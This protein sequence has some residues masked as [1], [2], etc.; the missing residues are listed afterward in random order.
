MLSHANA[1]ADYYQDY[2]ILN[3]ISIIKI[4][5]ADRLF[6]FVPRE[7]YIGYMTN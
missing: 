1:Q 7:K 4:L 3:V 2:K 5:H 6:V